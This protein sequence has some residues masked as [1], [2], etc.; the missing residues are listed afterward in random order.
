MMSFG[1]YLLYET[2]PRLVKKYTEKP[3][4]GLSARK[5]TVTTGKASATKHTGPMAAARASSVGDELVLSKLRASRFKARSLTLKNKA[6]LKRRSAI[7]AKGP[8]RRK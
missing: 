4:P 3:A 2:D 6:T 5:P 1:E 7:L 8:K